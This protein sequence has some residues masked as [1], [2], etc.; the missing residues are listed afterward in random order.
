MV[1]VKCKKC[2][3][4]IDSDEAY[5]CH[6]RNDISYECIDEEECNI[7]Y[8]EIC[9]KKKNEKIAEVLE[10]NTTLYNK[11]DVN[12]SELKYVG[13]LVRD[14]TYYYVKEYIDDTT[15]VN[16]IDFYYKTRV[17]P[18]EWC[19]VTDETYKQ[20]LLV[21]YNKRTFSTE[22]GCEPFTYL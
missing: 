11:Y 19:K 15:G 8:N 13:I 3:R 16:K 21:T 22:E 18:I 12:F 4:D 17:E 2:L 14:A 5:E 20:G 6:N 10:I 1:E 7:I 9:E